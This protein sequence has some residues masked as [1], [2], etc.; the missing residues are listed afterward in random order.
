MPTIQL[1]AKWSARVTSE[2]LGANYSAEISSGLRAKQ[3]EYKDELVC[4]FNG[5]DD[6]EYL[7]KAIMPMVYG[8]YGISKTGTIGTI[9]RIK[10]KTIQ[11]PR[12]ISENT[13][14]YYDVKYGWS[15][16][17]G[18]NINF[19]PGMYWLFS[20]TAY[21]LYLPTL[22]K[23]NNAAISFEPDLIGGY[24]AVYTVGTTRHQNK[25]YIMFEYFDGTPILTAQNPGSA[26]SVY[27]NPRNDNT[28][29]AKVLAVTKELASWYTMPDVLSGV[30]KWRLSG[31]TETHSIDIDNLSITDPDAFNP[32]GK[33]I[34]FIVFSDTL[35][36]QSNIEWSLQITTEA[37]KTSDDFEVWG[38]ITTADAIPSAIAVS[39]DGEYINGSD[40]VAFT[41]KYVNQYGTEQTAFEIQYKAQR[42]STWTTKATEETADKEY[43]MPA[44]TLPPGDG[45]WR[46]RVRNTDG[47]WGE[48]SDP[49][50]IYVQAAPSAPVINPVNAQS[51]MPT[52]TWQVYG[53]YAY[54]TEII[55][56]GAVIYRTGLRASTEN[57]HKVEDYLANG[58]YTVRVRIEGETNLMSDWGVA[59][60]IIAA[61]PLA[62]PTISCAAINGGV[63]IACQS[64]GEKTIIYRSMCEDVIPIAILRQRDFIFDDF[65]CVDECGYFAR[66][67]NS[68]GAYGDSPWA[69]CEPS[70]TT[71]YLAALDN[72]GE[73]VILRIR[74]NEKPGH[75]GEIDYNNVYFHVEG[76]PHP[77]SESDESIDRTRAMQFSVRSRAH[78]DRIDKLA[79]Q[80]KTV[81]FRD[82]TGRRMVGK[83]DHISLTEPGKLLDFS[84]DWRD[85][86]YDEAVDL[87]A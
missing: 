83:I 35:P 82:E 65:T 6:T 54:E 32:E 43:V 36:Q 20:D 22:L 31:D 29:R 63:R 67:A 1:F 50:E 62:A 41:W 78:F 77:V 27:I 3:G 18:I 33:H 52:I 84:L 57:S 47:V 7:K 72:P 81:I 79:A 13:V 55:R 38:A 44:N 69:H 12:E 59:E 11:A 5:Y 16:G 73:F 61:S 10:V 23:K 37:G 14:T 80:K 86:D 21:S 2:N 40:P 30:F 17:T 19:T 26:N 9:D 53:Q 76:R 46:V 15:S 75:S 39:P 4:G 64:P 48:Y 85:V 51:A 74:L 24:D 60:F 49:L 68:D 66:A 8:I 28:F 25:P 87:H 56:D 58:E 42:E 34:D 71:G 45:A 70:L